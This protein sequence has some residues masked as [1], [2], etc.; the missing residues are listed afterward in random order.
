MWQTALILLLVTA[1]LVY[2]IRHYV[3]VYR[4]EVP[5]C[6]CCSGCCSAKGPENPEVCE[7]DDAGSQQVCGEEPHAG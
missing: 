4:S 3:R 2:V 1:V 7:C 6:S 5:S